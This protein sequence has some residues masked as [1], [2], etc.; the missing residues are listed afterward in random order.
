MADK[1][2]MFGTDGVRGIANKELTIDLA[3]KIGM[4]AAKVLCA[5]SKGEKIKVLIGMDTRISSKMLEAALTAGLCSVGADVIQI[6][7][8]PT[9]AV[10]YLVGVYG[11]DA[12]IMI[13]ASHNSCEYNGIKLFNSKGFKLSDEIED[14]IESEIE[15]G[16]ENMELPEGG[17]VGRV[18]VELD[19]V[20]KYI[21]HIIS[22]VD[23][24]CKGLKVA[25][26]CANGS[27]SVT[28]KKIFE[29]LGAEIHIINDT[30]DGV[31][32]NEQCGSTYMDG[33]MEY[34][35]ANKMDIGLA[36]DGDA[37]RCLAVDSDG[38]MVDG[39]QLI[40]IAALDMKERNLLKKDTAVVTVMS[41]MGF[42]KFAEDNGINT[43]K[44][45]VG[46]RYVLECMLENGYNIGGEQSGH[47][48]FLDYAS[49]GDGQLTGVQ[50]LGIMCRKGETLKDLAK[51][52]TIYPQ[53]L[54]NIMVSP[55]SK[56][57]FS[58]CKPI[59]D[60]VENAEKQMAG[61]GR[62]LVRASG[63]EPKIRVMLEGK[64]YNVIEKICDDI[65][66]VIRENLC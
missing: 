14:K 16:F 49:T 50:M 32:I 35:K 28:A 36:F 18:T 17:D 51:V 41:N 43:E 53:V 40:A 22:S 33:L 6:G 42:W 39:D 65:I 62:V 9:P 34:V 29:A 25:L 63:T 61:D 20:D 5:D 55:A 19:A 45:G 54:K 57:K 38:N 26:D 23:V 13:S 8:V 10:A 64:D 4:A 2:R 48:I 59:W 3:T 46:D 47:I 24:D 15:A 56:D 12:G 58:T 30:P 1:K 52:M 21:Q 11:A 37:D 27:S 60:A 44:T 7:V 31:N 66:N